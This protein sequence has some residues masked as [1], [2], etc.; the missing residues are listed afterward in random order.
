MFVLG[1]KN[2][3]SSGEQDSDLGQGGMQCHQVSEQRGLVLVLVGKD[4]HVCAG[5]AFLKRLVSLFFIV[6]FNIGN[7]AFVKAYVTQKS[8]FGLDLFACCFHYL[9][10]GLVLWIFLVFALNSLSP[11]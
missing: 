3:A 11:T 1:V 9:V 4:Q 7:E 10:H 8:L 2:Y 6:S 5:K